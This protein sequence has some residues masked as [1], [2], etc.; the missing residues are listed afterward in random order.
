MNIPPM[1][2]KARISNRDRNFNL[3]LPLFLVLPLVLIIMLALFLILLPL[4]LVAA[5]VFWRFALWRPLLI[6]WTTL[7]G[8]L[9]AMRGLEVDII[10]DYEKVFISFN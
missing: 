6:F 4:L 9:T 10:Q 5:L 2:L 8:C 1:I 7:F 3:W